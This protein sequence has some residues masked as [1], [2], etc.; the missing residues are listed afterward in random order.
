VSSE[1]NI[2]GNVA[3]LL[4]EGRRE[5]G[6]SQAELA[7]RAGVSRSRI[8]AAE[9]R[10]SLATM[11][12]C[13]K[14]AE[15]LGMSPATMVRAH[16]RDTLQEVNAKVLPVV[17]AE[18]LGGRS[19]WEEMAQQH[20]L[21]IEHGACIGQVNQRG[22]VQI[23]RRYRGC[24]ATRPRARIVFRDRIIGERAPAFAIK[25]SPKGLGFNMNVSIEGEW[26]QHR[27]EFHRQWRP[28][29]GAF[30]LEFETTMPAG[31]VLDREEYNRRRQAEGLPAKR[32]W[33]GD[34]RA[35]VSY[36]FE[37]FDLQITF[38]AGYE[39]KWC[40]PTATWG[41]AP[42]D[43]ADYFELHPRTCQSQTFRP[44]KREALLIL[45]RPVPGYT[46][47]LQWTPVPWDP[48]GAGEQ[49]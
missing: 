5:R 16:V 24:Y 15:A 49:S 19:H 42:L 20:G 38:P 10:G 47:G 4:I 13:L 6:L 18:F 43:D 40:D 14:L 48:D 31:Y 27:V 22:D 2:A 28:E 33:R 17:E 25:G 37:R 1:R 29:D 11:D 12:I 35:P 30:D 8:I 39:P 21:R 45:E 7:E 36:A 3:A 44:S 23:V 9:S 41:T 34:Y 46:F 26:A 32:D